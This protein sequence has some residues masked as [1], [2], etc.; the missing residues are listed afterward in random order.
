[1]DDAWVLSE[2]RKQ[3]AGGRVKAVTM[4]RHGAEWQVN[5]QR[6]DGG[7]SVDTQAD[8]ITA[9]GDALVPPVFQPSTSRS[10]IDD[11]LG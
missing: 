9:L 10:E 1:M 7:W 8:P 2:L 6:P 3:I 5:V 4:W 11:L